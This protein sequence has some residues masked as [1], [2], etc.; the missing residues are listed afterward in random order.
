MSGR[1]LY[2]VV[3]M[4]LKNLRLAKKL[5]F[6]FGALLLVMAASSGF[7]FSQITSL[8]AIETTN[9]HSDDAELYVERMNGDITATRAAVMKF[10]LTNDMADQGAAATTLKKFADDAAELRAILVKDGPELLPGV[11]AFEAAVKNWADNAVAAEIQLA[12]DPTTLSESIAVVKAKSTQ[13]L[14][15]AVFTTSTQLFKRVTAWSDSYTVRAQEGMTLMQIIVAASGITCLLIGFA[16]AWLITRSIARPINAMTSAMKSLAQ[17]DNTVAIPAADQTDEIGEMAQTVQVFKDAAIEKLRLETEAAAARHAAEEESARHEA[18]QAERARQLSEVV[19]GLAGA[20]SKLAAGDLVQRLDDPFADEYEGLRA[21]FNGAI[22]Q[23]EATMQ[24][25]QAN[26]GAIRSGTGEI[27]TAS[28]DL[29]RRTEQQAASLEETAA[30]LDQITATVKKTAEGAEHARKVVGTARSDAE[31]SGDVV[32]RAVAAMGNIEASSR[33]I[34]QIIGV[35]DE[36]AFQTNLLALNAGVEAA[37]AGDAGRGFAVVAS[38]VRSLAQRSAEAAKEIKTLIMTSDTQVKEGVKLV[39][40]TGDALNRIVSQVVE[41]TEVVGEIAG[42]A[43]EQAGGLAQVNTAVNQMDQVTQQNAAMVEESTAAAHGLT[44]ETDQLGRLIGRFQV[45]QVETGQPARA[46]KAKPAAA[47]KLASVRKKPA[48][49]AA[50]PAPRGAKTG[51]DGW[52][53]F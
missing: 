34:G 3:L 27:A 8:A 22:V 2:E 46:D 41:I 40:E 47:V 23:L 15:E 30:A 9:S 17:G 39:S 19:G 5:G 32:A 20:L 10:I 43:H 1:P 42:S 11:A 51:T 52:E 45:S 33:Q 37:R 44:Q 14:Y 31:H 48:P 13:A 35:I 49:V 7:L 4:T 50:T 36:I 6:G 24:E 29:S 26:T 16:A 38:E 28:D 12:S 25:I 21:D 18:A 53:E